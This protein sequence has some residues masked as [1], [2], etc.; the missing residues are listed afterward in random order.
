MKYPHQIYNRHSI[1]PLEEVLPLLHN[2][3][4]EAAAGKTPAK[5]EINGE[6]VNVKSLRLL[7]FA[8][9]GTNCVKCGCEGKFF[10]IESNSG[11]YHLNLWAVDSDGDERLMTHDH[12]LARSLGGADNL[13]NTQP[14]CSPCNSEKAIGES[15][16]KKILHNK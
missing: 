6:K 9:K 16:M 2:A 10:A 5:V 12:I 14:M 8:K 11:A 4:S 15:A 3:I 7:T 13:S 1:A